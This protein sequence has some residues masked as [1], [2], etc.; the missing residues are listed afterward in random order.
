MWT[1]IKT[2]EFK[3]ALVF[4]NVF[5][6]TDGYAIHATEKIEGLQGSYPNVTG[7]YTGV[8]QM[9]HAEKQ[10]LLNALKSL[11]GVEK[12]SFDETSGKLSLLGNTIYTYSEK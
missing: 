3:Y 8:T 7:N 4:E 6:V 11:S 9:K 1:F 10:S 5:V 12:W 2:F